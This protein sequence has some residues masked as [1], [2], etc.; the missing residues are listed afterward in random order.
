MRDNRITK[1]GVGRLCMLFGKS[2]QAY[3]QKNSFIEEIQRVETIVL[4]LVAGIRRELPCVGV[5]KLHWLMQTPLK[6]HD[7]KM[8]RDKL[9]VLLRNHG[10]LV[11]RRKTI[12]KTTNSV[13]WLKKYPNLVKEIE[14]NRSEQVWVSDITYICVGR[15]FNYLSLI[16]DAY[17]KKIVGYYL[18]TLL[19]SDGSL[20]ALEM[21]LKGRTKSDQTLIHHSDRGVQ[22]CSFDYVR[23]LREYDIDISMTENGDPYEN[24]IAERINGILKG[25]FGLDKL[26]K[27][28]YEAVYAVEKAI[29]SYNVL[30]PHMSCDY[31][32]PNQAH[33]SDLELIKRW[34]PKKRRVPPEQSF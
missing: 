18:H 20:Q 1:M 32:T 7:I 25:E 21:A 30:R 11:K 29:N 5:Q 34:K 16:T 12:P 13:H 19:T 3:Y 8:G 26:F 22:Y 6:A 2:R 17:S 23:T 24:A 28:H 15:D 33:V 10:L 9:N 31:M 27:T 4:E 14:I